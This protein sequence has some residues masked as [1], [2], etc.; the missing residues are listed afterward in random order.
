MK[1]AK[2]NSIYLWVA[3]F[4]L[5]SIIAVGSACLSLERSH[6]SSMYGTIAKISKEMESLRRE[7]LDLS[8]RIAKLES[9]EHLKMRL[10]KLSPIKEDMLVTQ[11]Y[12]EVE[13]GKAYKATNLAIGYNFSN[14]I[15]T[16]N[17][18]N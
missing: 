11:S 12:D 13:N 16:I 5:I 7:S 3:I 4:T 9:P 17:N 18:F 6:K 8:S 1:N 14:K 2:D 10:G 15:G